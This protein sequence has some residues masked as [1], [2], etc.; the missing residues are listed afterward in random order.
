M[1]CGA[2]PGAVDGCPGLE[3]MHDDAAY[4]TCRGCVVCLASGR[5]PRLAP[6]RHVSAIPS[7]SALAT[8]EHGLPGTACLV[9]LAN[10]HCVAGSGSARPAARSVNSR[11]L[12]KAGSNLSRRGAAGPSQAT[13]MTIAVA[14]MFRLGARTRPVLTSSSRQAHLPA[15]AIRFTV[16]GRAR[17]SGGE[18]D[19]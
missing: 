7:G 2:L 1:P 14:N 11:V 8:G 13:G 12:I 19:G 15:V 4:Q 16:A 10:G 6:R 18:R 5:P 17:A 9:S 3:R